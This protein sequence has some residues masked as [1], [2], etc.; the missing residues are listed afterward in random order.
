LI[1]SITKGLEASPEGNLVI[2]PDVLASELPVT[3]RDRIQY[4]AV[5]G[6]CIAGELAGHRQTCVVFGSRDRAAADKLASTFRTSY[7]HLWPTTDLVGLEHGAALKNA[8][9]LG[10]GLAR[11]LLEKQNGPDAA[12]AYMHNTAAAIFAQGCCEMEQWLRIVGAS[13]FFAY[14]L[15]GAGDLYVTSAG[16]RTVRLGALFGKGHTYAEAREIMIGETLESVEIV[17]AMS[18][19]LP[20]M[21]QRHLIRQDDFPLM[22]T[23]IDIIVNGKVVDLCFDDF[24][25]SMRG[26]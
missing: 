19:V 6:P 5:G 20:T 4:G 12:N 22:R 9:T 3:L 1:I 26:A 24:F 15:P 25:E 2:L 13:S 7:Y 10:V 18:I 17:R 23:L 14:G 21:V 16:G 8:Y 11:G